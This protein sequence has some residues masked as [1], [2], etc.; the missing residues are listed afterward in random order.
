[1]E[2]NL[3]RT[4]TPWPP[5]SWDLATLALMSFYYHP[6]SDVARAEWEVAE[7]AIITAG[8]LPNP[9]MSVLG[10][11][12]SMTTGG[13]SPWTSG[14]SLDIPIETAGKRGYRIRE[15]K[16]LSEAARLNIATTAW[17]VWS[18]LRKSLLDLYAN[19]ERERFL[20]DQLA[21]E[22][23]IARLFEKRL[24]EGESSLFEVTQSRLAADKTRLMLSDSQ[25]KEAQARSALAEALGLQVKALDGGLG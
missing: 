9:G 23:A 20:L 14:F 5:R 17:Q 22:E 8:G 18:G 1:M 15:A 25:Q 19:T 24:S 3:H 2:K 4:I 21:A 16:Q 10:Q 7:A 12:H 11:H 6:D 13:L